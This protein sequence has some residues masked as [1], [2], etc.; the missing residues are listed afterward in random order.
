MPQAAVHKEYN[1][2]IKGLITEA[3]PLT[4]P[5]NASIDEANFVL[6][7][8]GSR[9]RR[10]GL[11]YEAGYALGATAQESSFF[12]EAISTYS[13]DNVAG[14][15]SAKVALVQVGGTLHLYDADE[16]S[17]S[18]SKFSIDIDLSAYQIE[19]R[20]AKQYEVSFAEV[21]GNLIVTSEAIEPFFITYDSLDQEFYTEQIQLNIRDF[22]GINDALL[23]DENPSTLSDEH[24]YNLQN[25]GW[26]GDKISTYQ[27]VTGT[28]PSNTQ[29]WHAGKDGSDVF[30]AAELN[31][32]D[33]G[34]TPA[35]KGKF[36]LNVFNRVYNTTIGSSVSLSVSSASY[37]EG[38][39]EI[40]INTNGNHG[41]TTG[42][43]AY[44]AGLEIWYDSY[45][46]T[47]NVQKGTVQGT[48]EVTVIDSNSLKISYYTKWNSNYFFRNGSVS[49]YSSASTQ[50]INIKEPWRV[51]TVASYGGRCF[52]AGLQ[53]SQYSNYVFFSKIIDD[54]KD[55][56]KCYQEADPTSEIFS[57]LVATDGGYIVIA[58]A[59]KI[60]K[61][62]AIGNAI[63]VFATNGI[64]KITGGAEGVFSALDYETSKI[65]EVGAV[66]KDSIVAVEGSV[67]YWAEG[68]IYILS[69]DQISGNLN[70]NNVSETTVQSLYLNIPSVSRVYATGVYDKAVKR[71]SWLYSDA[72]D[73]DGVSYRYKYNKEL[74]FDVAVGAFFKNEFGELSSLSPYVCGYVKTSDVVSSDVTYDIE[75]GTDEVLVGADTVQIDINL[76]GRGALGIKYLTAVPQAGGTE[77]KFTF[78]KYTNLNFLDWETADGT[79]VSYTSYLITGHELLGDTTRDKQANYATFHFKRTE[80]GFEETLGALNAV[81][82][83][84]CL[85]QSR[86]GWSDHTNSG[87]WGT[88]FQAYRLNRNYIPTGA[89]DPFNYGFEVI[90][91]K[92]KVRGH[93]KALSVKIESEPNKDM[94]LLGWGVDYVGRTLT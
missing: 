45:R 25:Q 20:L 2:F 21:R 62:L 82:P 66:N 86:W 47:P 34:N 50:I 72:D 42:D 13:W 70:A 44:I 71:V 24:S 68:G 73:Y 28:Y 35:P 67:M 75:V 52:Y 84:S 37:N 4:Y 7:R 30:S 59:A 57:D 81:Q 55:L 5:E 9:Q 18:G 64:W 17:L 10:L 51:S 78:S 8:D 61:L 89:A 69:P 77:T 41:L 11:D 15:S 36:L 22:I 92:N 46:V 74:I 54:V 16:A 6:N 39:R 80:T 31:K 40:T 26:Y 88:Q 85:V 83:S 1:T 94:H 76:L 29:I 53:N 43:V 3:N 87:R 48:F 23:V 38:A 12:E 79:G 91:T 60:I 33:F 90:T 93:G 19:D 27:S 56:S 14:L 32:Q 63:L 58:E 49:S 65:T